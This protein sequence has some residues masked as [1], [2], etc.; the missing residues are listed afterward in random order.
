MAGDG[1]KGR[2]NGAGPDSYLAQRCGERDGGSGADAA[3]ADDNGRH[4]ASGGGHQVLT[5]FLQMAAAAA[6][7]VQNRQTG[8]QA[9]V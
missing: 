1:P 9:I 3:A 5:G 6:A 4:C 8:A 2:D 7:P